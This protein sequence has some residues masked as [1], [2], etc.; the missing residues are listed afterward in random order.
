MIEIMNTKLT[1]TTKGI[2][3]WIPSL[4]RNQKGIPTT[5]K[6]YVFGTRVP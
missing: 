5:F 1:E 3:K 6:V 2:I 4:T